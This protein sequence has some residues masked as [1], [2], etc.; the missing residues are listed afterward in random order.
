MKSFSEKIPI[1]YN[2]DGIPNQWGS[3]DSIFLSPIISI[4]IWFMITFV[5]ENAV[6]SS[7]KLYVLDFALIISKVFK[8]VIISIISFEQIV[9]LYKIH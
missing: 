6:K 7:Y 5:V 3:K 4:I 1:H 8:L 9:Y 2:L